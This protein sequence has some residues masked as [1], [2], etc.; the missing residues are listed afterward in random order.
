MPLTE[1]VCPPLIALSSTIVTSTSR[2]DDRILPDLR[3]KGILV[4]HGGDDQ[5]NG[6]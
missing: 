3:R 6:F 2:G 5:L 1:A 4:V